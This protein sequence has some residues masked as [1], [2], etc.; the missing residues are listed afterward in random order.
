MAKTT[1][2]RVHFTDG[3]VIELE[4]ESPAVARDL[5]RNAKGGGIVSK[6]KRVKS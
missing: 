4:A 6:V 3:D 5:A 2:F 1:S